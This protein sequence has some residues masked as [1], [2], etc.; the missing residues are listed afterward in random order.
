MRIFMFSTAFAPSIGGIETLAALLAEEFVA[1]GHDVR[2]MTDVR[3]EDGVARPFPLHRG[4]SAVTYLA[5]LRWC[6][7]HLQF[8]LSL[9]R[10]LPVWARDRWFVAHGGEYVSTDGSVRTRDRLKLAAARLAYNI[11]CSQ[12]ILDQ[13]GCRG[14]VIGNAYD[15]CCFRLSGQDRVHELAFVGRLVSQKGC[16]VLLR[17]LGELARSGLRPALTVIG[18]GEERGRLEALAHVAGVAEQVTFRGALAPSAIA[19]ALNRH[20]ILVAPSTCREGYGIVALEGLASGCG[21]VVSAEGGLVEAAGGLAR[22]FRNGD[23]AS[24]AAALREALCAPAP[25]DADAVRS[26]LAGHTRRAVAERYLAA[27]AGGLGAMPG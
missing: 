24:L 9:K 26:H 17:A 6:D 18:D 25:P 23:P 1:L 19:G 7:A 11:S 27:F 15:D 4:Y 2:V 20:R 12:F 3:E 5:W 8:N 21:L 16:D 10:L 13:L 14:V 22:T